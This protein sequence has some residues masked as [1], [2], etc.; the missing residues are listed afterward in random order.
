MTAETRSPRTPSVAVPARNEV[1]RL[2]RLLTALGRQ[3]WLVEQGRRLRV[4]LVVNNT[5]DGSAE[6][7]RR[8]G[9]AW[10]GLDLSVLEVR[11]PADRAHVGWA[12]R[13]AM[14]MALEAETDPAAVALFST[15]ADAEP[16]PDWIAQGLRALEMGADVVGGRIIGDA[17]EEAA[18]GPGFRRRARDQARYHELADHLAWLCDR[19]E[20]DPWPRHQDHTGASLTLGGEVYAALGGLPP[21]PFR[22]DLALVSKACAAGYRLVHP[23]GVRVVVSARL[24]GRAVGGMANCLSAWIEAEAVGAPHLVEAPARLVARLKR[25]DELRRLHDRPTAARLVADL[26][27]DGLDG[28]GDTPVDQAIA[29]LETLIAAEQGAVRAA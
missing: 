21:V 8:E 12:R 22:E 27:W 6:V 9:L 2:P 16:A 19:V 14:D 15:D 25:R 18:L 20:D 23:P 10:P 29:E 1:E 26:A 17:A 28:I 11:L 3:T 5:E 13:M 4:S 24:D 7:A